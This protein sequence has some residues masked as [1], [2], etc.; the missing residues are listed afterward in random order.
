[1]LTSSASPDLSTLI[2]L[3]IVAVVVGIGVFF[4]L[5]TLFRWL[6]NTTMPE[7]FDLKQLTY[8]QA[9]RL[10]IMILM[11]SLILSSVGLKPFAFQLT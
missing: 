7:V 6:W 10:L 1:M 5:T 11:V 9:L 3:L 8:W 4:A 2:L